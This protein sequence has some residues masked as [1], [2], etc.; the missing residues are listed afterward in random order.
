MKTRFNLQ[1][2]NSNYGDLVVCISRTPP[3]IQREGLPLETQPGTEHRT[4]EDDVQERCELLPAEKEHTFKISQP[5][6]WDVNS[7]KPIY[8]LL[9]VEATDTI[10]FGK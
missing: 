1:F 7:C 6:P 9:K 8:F 2:K 10:C 4:I 5:C 3:L